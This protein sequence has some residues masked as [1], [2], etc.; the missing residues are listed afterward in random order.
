MVKKIHILAV[1][2]AVAMAV[3]TTVTTNKERKA[4]VIP[5]FGGLG[6]GQTAGQSS[7]PLSGLAEWNAGTAAAMVRQFLVNLILFSSEL[8]L[9]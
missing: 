8:Y 1:L 5:L 7:D 2:V 3:P 9:K 4:V 6:A